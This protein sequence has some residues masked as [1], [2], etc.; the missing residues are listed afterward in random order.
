MIF[1]C[2]FWAVVKVEHVHAPDGSL[3]EH[4]TFSYFEGMWDTK[5]AADAWIAQQTPKTGPSELDIAYRWHYQTDHYVVVP[6]S[7]VQAKSMS[8]VETKCEEAA[9]L[10]LA[11]IGVESCQQS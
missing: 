3:C 7:G 8:D 1:D 9:K 2:N 10:Q 4:D 5:E 11:G 6:C